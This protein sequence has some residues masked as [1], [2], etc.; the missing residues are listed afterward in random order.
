MRTDGPQEH[1]RGGGASERE[2]TRQG[3]GG[4]GSR[5]D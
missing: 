2:R 3:C 1:Q 4:N 5:L